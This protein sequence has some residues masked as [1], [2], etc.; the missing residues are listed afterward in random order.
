MCRQRNVRQILVV[1]Q[2]PVGLQST[3]WLHGDIAAMASGPI[4]HVHY[5]SFRVSLSSIIG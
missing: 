4:A 3:F 1:P 2:H 5:K